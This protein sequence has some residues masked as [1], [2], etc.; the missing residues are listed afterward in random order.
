[1]PHIR[2]VRVKKKGAAQFGERLRQVRKEAEEA[3]KRALRVSGTTHPSN[4]LTQRHYG[5]FEII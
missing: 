4:K 1:M 3:M 5:P 2:D